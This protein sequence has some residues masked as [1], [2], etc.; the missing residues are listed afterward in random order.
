M[1]NSTTLQAAEEGGIFHAL[2]LTGVCSLAGKVGKFS[3]IFRWTIINIGE[4]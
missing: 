4:R 3:E 1:D 2:Y